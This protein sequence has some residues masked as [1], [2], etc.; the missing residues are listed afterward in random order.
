VAADW[1]ESAY[2]NP[3]KIVAKQ[4]DKGGNNHEKREKIYLCSDGYRHSA[5]FGSLRRL[6]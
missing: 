1:D 6:R 5:E 2:C 3:V 4:T